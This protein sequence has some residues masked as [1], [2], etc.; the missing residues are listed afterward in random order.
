MLFLK[1]NLE[2]NYNISANEAAPQNNY[3]NKI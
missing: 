1:E 2:F 3:R